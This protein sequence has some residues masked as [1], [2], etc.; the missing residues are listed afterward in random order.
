[1]LYVILESSDDS[2]TVCVGENYFPQF[3][4]KTWKIF[5]NKDEYKIY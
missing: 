4:F 5:T 1:M 2:I 3:K